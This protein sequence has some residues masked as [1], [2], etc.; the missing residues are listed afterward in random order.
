[1]RKWYIFLFQKLGIGLLEENYVSHV[2]KL[3]IPNTHTKGKYKNY[4]TGE[5][6]LEKFFISIKRHRCLP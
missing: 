3:C 6:S 2:Y 1:M 5:L 4:P